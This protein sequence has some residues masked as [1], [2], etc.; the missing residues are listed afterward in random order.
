MPSQ[1]NSIFRKESLERLSS[2]ERL[3]QLMQ[4]IKAK[5]WLPLSTL[6]VLVVLAIVWSI[7]G[8]IPV[9]VSGRGVLLEAQQLNSLPATEAKSL[10]SAPLANVAYF[11][12]GDGKRIEEGMRVMVT[13]DTVKREE[14]GSIFATVTSVSSFP[15]TTESAAQLIGNRELAA[16]LIS[17]TGKMQVVAQLET[18]KTSFSG[19]KWTSANG[20][21]RQQL[22]S[23]TTTSV[24]VILRE[25]A[26]ISIVFPML[27]PEN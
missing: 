26:P 16:S 23:G 9:T 21:P 1:D 13:P 6:G 20:S 18:D 7:L 5:D 24:R 3:D 11:T 2:P 27:Q 15:I 12:I 19:Y 25:Q 10:N 17:Q 22:S 4:V 14:F 8:R